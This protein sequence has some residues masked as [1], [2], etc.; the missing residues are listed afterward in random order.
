M[1]RAVEC[2]CGE[3]IEAQNDSAL[4]DA[5]RRHAQ[6]DHPDWGEGELKAHLVANAYDQVPEG[7]S[8]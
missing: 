7:A 5:F 3:H 6:E 4:L 1:R 2:V 8:T